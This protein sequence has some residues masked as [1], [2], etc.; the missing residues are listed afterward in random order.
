MKALTTPLDN[1]L[2]T[3]I[4][5]NT[6]K[7]F[8]IPVIFTNYRI[9]IRGD[10]GIYYL[11]HAGVLLIDGK[12][13]QAR[14]YEYGRYNDPKA[15]TPGI[16]RG[17]IQQAV[18]LDNGMITESSFKTILRNISQKHGQSGNISGVVMRGYFYE[19]AL[20]WIN[21]KRR[22]NHTSDKKPYNLLNHN[23]MTF[24]IDLAEHLGLDTYWRPPVVMPTLY[25]EQFQL[26]Y[27]D[28]DYDFKNNILEVPE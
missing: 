9:A 8:M 11:G 10:F 7:D 2:V 12:T 19:D 13:G 5:L 23:C 27:T 6:D 3:D 21:K 16:V 28:L 24:V 20:D 26:Q 17:E 4:H 18:V 14:Y 22:E 15:V 1:F 25:A